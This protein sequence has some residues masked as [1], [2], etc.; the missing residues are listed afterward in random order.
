MSGL[1]WP[2]DPAIRKQVSGDLLGRL[3]IL[4]STDIEARKVQVPLGGPEGHERKVRIFLDHDHQGRLLTFEV[5][6]FR[7][8]CTADNLYSRAVDGFTGTDRLH[9]D[10]AA[11]ALRL[12]NDETKVRDQNQTGILDPRNSTTGVAVRSIL[13]FPGLRLLVYRTD[14]QK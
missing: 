9:E 12:F 10:I 2:V 13:L 4:D 14:V 7:E 5:H 1:A 8:L 11:A 3:R 6:Q